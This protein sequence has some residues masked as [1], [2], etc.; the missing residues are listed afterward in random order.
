[1]QATGTLR[2]AGVSKRF[3]LVVIAMVCALILGAAGGYAARNVSSG[4]PSV[5]SHS[6]VGANQGDPRS[7]LTRVLPTAAP[8]PAAAPVH[9]DGVPDAG[10]TP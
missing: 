8:A 4:A 5:Q 6:A 10:Y 1:M 3:I 2:E 7:D 9:Y